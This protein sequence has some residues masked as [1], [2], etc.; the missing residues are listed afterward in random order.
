MATSGTERQLIK[1]HVEPHPAKPG[2]VFW[3]LKQSQVPVWAIVA[4]LFPDLSNKAQV[5]ADYQISEEAI[6]A[7]WAYYQQHRAAIDAWLLLNN[8]A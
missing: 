7:A 4:A 1:A 2:E 5:A 3:R 6:D 8:A